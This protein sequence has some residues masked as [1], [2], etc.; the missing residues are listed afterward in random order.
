MC[1]KYATPK[2]KDLLQ[3]LEEMPP[4]TVKDYHEY[5]LA[6]GFAH[7]MMAITTIEEPGIIQPA[8]WGLIPGWAKTIEQANDI[9]LKTLNAVSETVY[10]KPSFKSYIGKYRCL[11]WVNGFYEW[12]W[13][14]EKGKSKIPYF[15]YMPNH[16]PFTFGGLYTH[17]ANPD[18]GELITTFSI[19]TTE[20]N[21]MMAQI[22]NNK[23]RMPLIIQP[24]DREKWLSDLKKDEIEAIMKPLPDGI[25]QAHTISKLITTRGVDTNVPEVQH[26][27]KYEL[28]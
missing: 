6:D 5:Y 12:Q 18:T 11:V 20:A 17:W 13:K 4:Y 24:K 15:I 2:L 7:P 26:E 27:Y 3:Y 19:L 21:E 14:D 28:F 9:A 25:L 8:M 10:E 22:H 1:Y 16:Q 23:K